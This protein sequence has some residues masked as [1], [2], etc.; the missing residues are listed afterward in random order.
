MIELLEV[1][2]FQCNIDMSYKPDIPLYKDIFIQE[3][4]F[5]SFEKLLDDLRKE[6]YF[7]PQ[8]GLFG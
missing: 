4:G 2:D 7:T 3:L 5:K 8:G 6:S 1:P